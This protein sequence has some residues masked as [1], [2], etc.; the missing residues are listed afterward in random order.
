MSFD[1]PS[2]QF[3]FEALSNVST[4]QKDDDS[5]SA[6]PESHKDEC[7]GYQS[8]G[9]GA[10]SYSCGHYKYGRSE[11]L[12][13]SQPSQSDLETS[14][15]LPEQESEASRGQDKGSENAD[16]LLSHPKRKRSDSNDTLRNFGKDLTNVR[17][18][19]MPAMEVLW[20]RR[21][22]GRESKVDRQESLA[23]AKVAGD[24]AVM[25]E[26]VNVIR[27]AVDRQSRILLEVCNAVENHGM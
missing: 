1:H 2:A 16:K 8:H 6:T 3:E 11:G 27:E 4:S 23:L 10:P 7:V 22:L 19:S 18:V 25:L 21:K 12:K 24:V 14:D 15:K 9:Q 17:A 20:K 13:H 5:R 26:A